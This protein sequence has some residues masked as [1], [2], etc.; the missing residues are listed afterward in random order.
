MKSMHSTAFILFGLL[1]EL[2]WLNILCD[3][4]IV[5]RGI[6]FVDAQTGTTVKVSNLEREYSYNGDQAQ[7]SKP[8]YTKSYYTRAICY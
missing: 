7:N 8:W 6:S 4:T 2:P 3:Q 5:G 1:S